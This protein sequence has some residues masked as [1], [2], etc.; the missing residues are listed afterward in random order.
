[1]SGRLK[2][3]KPLRNPDLVK[4]WKKSHPEEEDDDAEGDAE[5]R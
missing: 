5:E 1:M 3:Q 2:D 4:E